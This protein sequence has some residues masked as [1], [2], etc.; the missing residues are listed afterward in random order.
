[1]R[2]VGDL[3]KLVL[4]VLPLAA[5]VSAAAASAGSTQLYAV[6]VPVCAEPMPLLMAHAATCT[7]VRRV[8]VPAGT[9]G[10]QRLTPAAGATG[11]ATMGPN[12][13]LTPSDITT[14]YHLST[15][16]T[17]GSTQTIAIVDAFNDP[18]IQSDL[19]T[20]DAQYGLPCKSCLTVVSQ[21]G[22]SSNLPADDTAGWSVEESLDV[23]A[24][25]GACPACHI[26]VVEAT[27]DDNADLAAAENEA[28]KLHATEISNSFGEPEAADASFQA[29]FNHP[30]I[31]ITAGSGDDGY[32]SYDW[33]GL[34][35]IINSPYIPASYPT[36]V[37]VGGTSLYLA[38]NA[39]RASETVWNDNGVQAF[40]E[41]NMG[42]ALGATGGGC[43]TMFAGRGWQTNEP[44][45]S[46]AACGGKR[47]SA[48]IS[49]VG[50]PL[51]G[52][53]IYDSYAC[54]AAQC[55]T[56]PTWMT[57]GGTSLSSPLLAAA[58]ALSGGAHGVPYP[59]VT[60][61]G[62]AG[63]AYDVTAGGNGI[64]AGEG[65]AQCP[66]Y[67]TN[68]AFDFGA[69]MLDC[70]YTPSGAI[71]AGTGACDAATGFDGPSGIGTPNSMTLFAKTGPNFAIQAAGTAK[72]NVSMH[73]GTKSP[74]D[75]FPGGA[76]AKYTWNWGDGT[77]A[78]VTSGPASP[79]THKFATTGLKTVTV[80]AQ[81]TYGV[82]T[83]KTHHVTVS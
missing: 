68:G 31:V 79:V 23:E 14:A 29:A 58:Y 35:G 71:A 82:T 24:A 17:A 28:A 49:I 80:T 70:A 78:T 69:G 46:S 9:R 76:V 83:A 43:S 32:Y 19:Q 77:P 10:A 2:T 6:G 73:F 53:D 61:Y 66:D 4:L 8:L 5:L 51:T 11:T 3:P 59:A 57:I 22:S 26:L 30:G 47:L 34:N 55:P 37:A 27:S 54:G 56:G 41:V 67:S 16:P 33:L 75:P 1:M 60:L 62:H 63:S 21:T 64:C 40:D 74:T 20:F 39:T 48:D 15:S 42:M 38:Q 52:F 44:G 72:R 36:V 50:D 65:A 7:A 25:H 45:Y 13:G 81:D 12:F 18:N